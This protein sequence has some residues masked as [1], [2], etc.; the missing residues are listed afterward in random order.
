MKSS[1]D[2]LIS[3]LDPMHL[4][5]GGT[6]YFDPDCAHT[7]YRCMTCG[8]IAGSVGMPKSCKDAME[9]YEIIERLGGKGWDYFA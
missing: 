9:H 5:C 6:A 4:P 1:N 7:S 2:Q 8:A 3:T